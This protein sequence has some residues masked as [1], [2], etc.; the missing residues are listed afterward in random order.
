MDIQEFSATELILI[1]I[2]GEDRPGLTASVMEILAKYDATIMDIGQ[3]DIRHILVKAEVAE[4][5]EEPTDEAK[6]AAKE[7]AQ[8]I[9]DEFEAGDKTSESFAA[10]ANEYSEDPG[11]NTNGG[12]YEDVTENTSFFQGF[13]DWIF[14]DGRKV[15]DTGLVENTQTNQWGWHVMY[16]DKV[17]NPQWKVTADNALRSADM[18]AWTEELTSGIEAVDGSGLKYVE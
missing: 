15:G 12:L 7:K 13:L 10:L 1:R 5:A 8:S 11:S 9:L 18:S 6:E 17:D 4:G 2:T 16:L 3:A 14:A